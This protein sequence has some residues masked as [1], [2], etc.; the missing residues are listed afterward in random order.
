MCAEDRNTFNRGLAA[1]PF[2]LAR[3]RT[4]RRF[5]GVSAFLYLTRIVRTPKYDAF[6][7]IYMT[8]ATSYFALPVLPALRRTYSPSYRIPL[9]LYGS[10]GRARRIRA[11]S[12]PTCC[13]FDPLTMILVGPSIAN[14]TPS[15]G[16][17]RTGCEYPTLR[18]K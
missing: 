13:L 5:R 2:T 1:V 3:T 7:H 11:A 14:M 10:G 9:P 15:T 17:I 8:N 12:S 6:C 16:V 18:T 4:C